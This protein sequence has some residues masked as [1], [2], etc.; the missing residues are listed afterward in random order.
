M[1]AAILKPMRQLYPAPRHLRGD[2]DAFEAALTAYRQALSRFDSAVLRRT[3]QRVVETNELWCWPKIGELVRAA[4]QFDRQSHP[5]AQADDWVE[6]AQTRADGYVRKFL[7]SNRH[8]TRAREGGYEG[9]LRQYVAAA[10]WVQAQMIEGR[11][12]VGYDHAVLFP[13][14][15]DEAAEGRWF[16]EARERAS[17]GEIDVVV[18]RSLVARWR[19]EAEGQARAR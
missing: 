7:K 16:A 13:G 14:P 12:G 11:E 9:S 6:R 2:E 17:A 4:E 15:R 3:W 18:P 1:D 19:Q 5:L 10:A 8:A